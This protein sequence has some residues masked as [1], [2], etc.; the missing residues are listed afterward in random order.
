MKNYTLFVLLLVY[1]LS[2]IDRQIIS[3]LAEDIKGDLSLSDTQLGLLT[4]LAFAVFYAGLGVPVT[5]LSERKD[6]ISIVSVCVAIW[7]VMTSAGAF[8]GN[9]VQLAFARAGVG[10]E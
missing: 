8:A 9:F 2:F 3:I 10:I 6:R 5:R 4:G 1:L 7:S